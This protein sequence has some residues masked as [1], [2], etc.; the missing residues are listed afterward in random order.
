MSGQ[1]KKHTPALKD[2][3][4]SYAHLWKQTAVP[5]KTVLLKEGAIS[6]K[7]FLIEKG[8]VRLWFNNNGKDITFQFF[9]ENEGVSSIE[10]FRSGKPSLFTIETIEPCVLRVIQKKDFETMLA[11][12][13]ELNKYVYE[14]IFERLLFY[15]QLFLSR[16][17]DNP[18]K[19]YLDLLKNHPRIIQRVPQQYIASY[20]GITAVSLS[21]IRNNYKPAKKS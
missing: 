10:S 14:T 7:A 12:S 11:A 13:P 20:L 15:Q 9:F 21:R 16:I 2:K 17:K 3:W 1:S 19:R 4:E 6:R 8:C 18:Q 5:A